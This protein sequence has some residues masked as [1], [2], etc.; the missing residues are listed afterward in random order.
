MSKQPWVILPEGANAVNEFY[1]FA[2]HW[3]Q[4][5]LDRLADVRARRSQQQQQQ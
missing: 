2:D 4:D 3:P 1:R 5:S